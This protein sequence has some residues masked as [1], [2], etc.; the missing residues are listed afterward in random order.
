MLRKYHRTWYHS[1]GN[2]TWKNSHAQK[3]VLKN[4]WSFESNCWHMQLIVRLCFSNNYGSSF[5][6]I[7]VFGFLFV[8]YS[9]KIFF[10]WVC[11]LDVFCKNYTLKNSQYSMKNIYNGALFVERALSRM[12]P[13][14]FCECFSAVILYNTCKRLPLFLLIWICSQKIILPLPL[15]I[16][17]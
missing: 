5:W 17:D 13:Y 11:C 10:Y 12:F 7:E 3:R 4:S 6:S 8:K 15:E 1:K 9:V 14:K 2:S 16:E